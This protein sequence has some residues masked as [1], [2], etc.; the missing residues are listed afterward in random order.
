MVSSELLKEH[1]FEKEEVAEDFREYFVP[2]GFPKPK[3]RFRV[4]YEVPDLNIEEP[5]F[6]ILK[7]LR[8]DAGFPHI[9]KTEDTYASAETSAFFGITQQRLGG[10]QDKVSQFLATIGKMVKELFQL[11]REL[12]ILDERL[13]Y[14]RESA[15]Q[16]DKPMNQRMKGAEITLKGMF[17]DLVQGGAKNAA[18]VYG[19]ARELEFTTLPDLFFDAPPFKDAAEMENYVNALDFNLKV[20]EVL[21]RHTRQFMEWKK[22]TNSE[23]INRRRFTLQY[24]RQHFDII[25]MYMEWSKPYL[26]NIQRMSP[27]DKH[28]SAPD[29]IAAF[30]GSMVDIELLAS[31]KYGKHH[32]VLI[33][34]FN[35]RTSPSMKFVQEGYQRGPVHVGQLELNIRR[36][37]WNK[38][39]IKKYREMKQRESLE[40][41]KTISDSVKAAMEALGDELFSYLEEAGEE[42][43][44]KKKKE[45]P[46][47]KSF[48][49]RMLGDFITVGKKKNVA[50]P[51]GIKDK[52][53]M[54]K[55]NIGA[56]NGFVTF[57]C[58][59]IYK[60]FKKSHRMV[61]W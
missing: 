48:T 58:Y 35:Y 26:K 39:Q 15:M 17:I 19:M 61:H 13:T 2:T 14:Y 30:E 45:T 3:K 12:R 36:Y 21:K 24:L 29:L 25:K 49:E 9:E 33:V 16:G 43:K 54:S 47:K 51:K 22:R 7:Y 50:K 20:K 27:K 46:Q 5:Y 44:N 42:V 57:H 53:T 38:H 28:A 40:L 52:L 60:I 41:L 6:W 1:G 34:T 11:V 56:A 23:M 8:Y 10:Q 32:G 55:D 37:L 59:N 4:M 31:R 18:S